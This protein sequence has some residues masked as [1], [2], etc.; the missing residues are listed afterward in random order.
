MS[1]SIYL[2][3]EFDRLTFSIRPD[4]DA[5]ANTVALTLSFEDRAKLR[6]AL[7]ELDARE[8]GVPDSLPAD[9][10]QPEALAGVAA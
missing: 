2:F 8:A 10:T 5:S 1:A 6:A 3:S 4:G 7:D 9:I